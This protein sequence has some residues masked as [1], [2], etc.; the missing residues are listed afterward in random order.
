MYFFWN[1]T[2]TEESEI[3]NRIKK[4]HTRTQM[5]K[6][7]NEIIKQKGNN[8]GVARASLVITYYDST[9]LYW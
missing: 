6:V 1:E 4:A 8:L 5:Y 2:I 9:L 3:E 7:N